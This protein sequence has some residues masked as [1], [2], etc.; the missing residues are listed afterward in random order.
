MTVLV[1]LIEV[2]LDLYLTGTVT[3]V[4]SWFAAAPCLA[5]VALMLL[6]DSNKA[7]KQELAKRLHF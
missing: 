6:L 4:W 3:L 7:V 5:I 2:L 1:L